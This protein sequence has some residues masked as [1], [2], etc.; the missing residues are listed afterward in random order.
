[1]HPL[2]IP[3][4]PSWCYY[5][6]LMELLGGERFGDLHCCWNFFVQLTGKAFFNLWSSKNIQ[7]VRQNMCFKSRGL[8]R[9]IISTF[10][11]CTNKLK[12]RFI[13]DTTRKLLFFCDLIIN[14]RSKAFFKKRRIRHILR[15]NLSFKNI[16]E[17]IIKLIT[18]S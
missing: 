1:M 13:F 18:T 12:I 9:K 16:L 6:L 8:Y 11:F 3:D 5:I 17:K 2:C 4:Q 14:T 10:L 15:L 7:S